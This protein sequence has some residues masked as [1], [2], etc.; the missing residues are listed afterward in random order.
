MKNTMILVSGMP[1][2]GKTSFASW[3]SQTLHSPLVCY[4][5]IKEKVL[6]IMHQSCKDPAQHHLFSTMPYN[7]FWFNVE[8]MMKSSTVFIAEY[9]FT[10]QMVDT[11]QSLTSQYQYETITVHMDT[12]AEFAYERFQERNLHTATAQGLRPMDI[13]FEQF[14]NGT[15]QNKD[16]RYGSRLIHVDTGDFS[17][18]SYDN[19]LSKIKEYSQEV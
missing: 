19:I 15:K 13:S 7:L 2:T 10:N 16:F 9:F 6:E 14:V 17:S 8:A 18:V 1:A 12:S 5:H 3:L 11:L 4:D